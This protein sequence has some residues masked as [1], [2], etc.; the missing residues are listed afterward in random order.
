MTKP[1]GAARSQRMPIISDQLEGRRML[2]DVIVC[3][4]AVASA[5]GKNPVSSSSAL[6]RDRVRR[7]LASGTTCDDRLSDDRASIRIEIS[8]EWR[9]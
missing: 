7:G 1:R 8:R 4:A 9:N 3:A 6:R 5:C 2:V